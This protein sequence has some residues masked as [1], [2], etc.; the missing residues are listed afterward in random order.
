MKLTTIEIES[1][2]QRTE[3]TTVGKWEHFPIDGSLEYIVLGE[4]RG[5]MV[6]EVIYEKVD[7]EFIAHSRQ[8]IPNLLAHIAE[9]EAEIKQLKGGISE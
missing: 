7:A 9:L 3:A 2:R 5:E 8:D 1:I 4:D 6:A